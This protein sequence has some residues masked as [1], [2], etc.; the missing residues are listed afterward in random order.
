MAM[1][2]INGIQGPNFTNEGINNVQAANASE[3]IF[4]ALILVSN[5]RQSSFEYP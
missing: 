5:L 2:D 1:G 4:V 3:R